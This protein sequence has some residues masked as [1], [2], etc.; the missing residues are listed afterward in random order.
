MN[1]LSRPPDDVGSRGS[2]RISYELLAVA[3]KLFRQ[4][5]YTAT[6]TRELS[7]RLG[8]NNSSLYYYISSKENLLF[9][10]C[11]RALTRLT[12]R[13][14]AA[15]ATVEPGPEQLRV[16]A[17]E[18]LYILLDNRDMHATM[19][20]ELKCLSPQNRLEIVR[21]RDAYEQ[22][23]RSV[24]EGAQKSGSMRPDLDPAVGTRLLLGALNWPVFW[25]SPPGDLALSG[26]RLSPGDLA[27]SLLVL[28]GLD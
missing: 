10:I 7:R 27:D 21:M 4:H 24:F 6:T 17:R 25:Y 8:F 1:V 22:L 2:V 28:L 13:M 5:G 14:E 19:L 16:L 18:H 3:A 15:L 26:G 11:R 12:E 23:V 20:I 9:E